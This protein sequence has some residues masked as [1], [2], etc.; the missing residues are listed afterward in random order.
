MSKF[1]YLRPRISFISIFKLKIII[2]IVNIG[3]CYL[4]EA[5]II[6][7]RAARAKIIAIDKRHSAQ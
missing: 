5:L 2:I 7:S 6:V 1:N 3:N 4:A